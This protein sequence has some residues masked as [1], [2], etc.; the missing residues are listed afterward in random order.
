MVA[1]HGGVERSDALSL[2]KLTLQ[3]GLLCFRQG[4]PRS[5][6]L[7]L[8]TERMD[9]GQT[10]Q[11]L[12]EMEGRVAHQHV[13]ELDELIAVVAEHSQIVPFVVTY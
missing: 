11:G 8:G 7:L 1:A 13:D 5:C 4:R 9:L 2:F 3:V 12:L 6:I 10:R